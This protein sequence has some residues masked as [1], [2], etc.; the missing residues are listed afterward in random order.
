M[1]RRRVSFQA[2][3]GPC[4]GC[5]FLPPGAETAA[6]GGA[7][8]GASN[9]V[10]YSW[11]KDGSVRLWDAGR[12]VLDDGSAGE[13]RPPQ[14]GCVEAPGCTLYKGAFAW[15][16]G[17]RGGGASLVLAL[18]GDLTAAAG[19]E[20]AAEEGGAEEGGAEEQWIAQLRYGIVAGEETSADAPSAD[21]RK[22]MRSLPPPAPGLGAVAAI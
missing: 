17:R 1:W 19:E 20:A 4:F 12:P 3:V 15:D 22:R 7:L 11:S 2:H 16:D 8:A 18:A 21:A 5:A 14:L 13:R 6:P 9:S 10:L